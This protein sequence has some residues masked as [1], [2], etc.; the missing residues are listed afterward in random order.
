MVRGFAEAGQQWGDEDG[1]EIIYEV[2]AQSFRR[3]FKL[4]RG[5]FTAATGRDRRRCRYRVRVAI[6]ERS[7]G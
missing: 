1:L 6:E 7:W 2:D 3:R 4:K 5:E